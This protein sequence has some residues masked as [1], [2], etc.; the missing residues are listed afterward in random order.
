MRLGSV[1]KQEDSFPSYAV[2]GPTGKRNKTHSSIEQP[3][4]RYR[5]GGNPATH[6]YATTASNKVKNHPPPT[7]PLHPTLHLL[8]CRSP[9]PQTVL[10]GAAQKLQE[11]FA[12]V[13]DETATERVVESAVTALQVLVLLAV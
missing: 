10:R 11:C 9:Q 4:S 1:C 6:S 7:H 13:Q 3:T 12:D 8:L 5:S 2:E